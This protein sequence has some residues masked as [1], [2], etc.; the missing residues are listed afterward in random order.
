MHVT[1][2]GQPAIAGKLSRTWFIFFEQLAGAIQG[3]GGNLK[4][5]LLQTNHVDNGSQDILD[6]VQGSGITIVDDGVGNVTI[7]ATGGGGGSSGPYNVAIELIGQPNG[8]SSVLAFFVFTETVSFEPN[9]SGSAGR[10]GTN[11]TGAQ[12]YTLEKNG[13]AV[14]TVSIST[15][16]VVT[17]ATSGGTAVSFASGD[18]LTLIG[19]SGSADATLADVSLTLAG[20]RGASSPENVI[21]ANWIGSIPAAQLVGLYTFVNSMTLGANF[22]GA[23][24]KCGTNPAATATF[25]VYKNGTAIGTVA[26]STAGAFT[27]ATSGGAAF[28]FSPGDEI[29]V[30][31]PAIA[32]A[33]LANV[34]ISLTGSVSSIR[35]YVTTWTLQTSVTIAH[36]LSTT[37]YS[38]SVYDANG[39]PADPETLTPVDVNSFTLG[40]GAAF[41]GR[42]VVIG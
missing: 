29:T 42:A 30:V 26:I 17:F 10:V 35:K 25:N 5:L 16:G 1:A 32:D 9:W 33:T 3:I 34:A 7:S 20:T 23:V 15:G 22:A 37:D 31:A 12:T 13:S 24:G 40:F 41:T 38:L 6:L 27:F 11:P 19:T 2:D 39:Q 14:G 4:K 28:S 8:G 21:T 18:E 36:S